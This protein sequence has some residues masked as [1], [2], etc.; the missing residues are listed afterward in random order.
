MVT[1]ELFLECCY[2][3]ARVFSHG[4]PRQCYCMCLQGW[5]GWF[6]GCSYW[7]AR[8]FC[9]VSRVL[10]WLVRVICR[11]LLYICKGV[12]KVVVARMLLYSYHRVLGNLCCYAVVRVF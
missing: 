3:V 11:V 6:V 5:S 8:M 2:A 9:V 12:R 10:L 1:K 4:L 7:V